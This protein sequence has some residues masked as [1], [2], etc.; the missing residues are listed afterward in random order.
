MNL[1]DSEVGTIVKSMEIKKNV[2][3][4]KFMSESKVIE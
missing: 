1:L 4:A 3:S 2:F